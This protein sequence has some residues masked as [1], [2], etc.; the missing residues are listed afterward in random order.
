VRRSLRRT[1]ARR[2]ACMRSRVRIRAFSSR[3][4]GSR[5]LF[6]TCFLQRGSL[7]FLT[8]PAQR[9]DGVLSPPALPRSV[10][11]YVSVTCRR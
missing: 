8:C 11:Y 1:Q 9:E 3:A 2:A 7:I 4:P 5:S 10:L 6:S